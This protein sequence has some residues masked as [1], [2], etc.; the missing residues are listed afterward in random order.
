MT[1]PVSPTEG[2]SKM[3]VVSSNCLEIQTRMYI[4]NRNGIALV[5]KVVVKVSITYKTLETSN[6]IYN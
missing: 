6:T 4:K 5:Q 3:S 1:L 2:I